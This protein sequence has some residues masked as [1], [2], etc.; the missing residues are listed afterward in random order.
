M[1][2]DMDMILDWFT[3]PESGV[4][5]GKGRAKRQRFNPRVAT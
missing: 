3:G 5:D 2:S 4:S 1:D